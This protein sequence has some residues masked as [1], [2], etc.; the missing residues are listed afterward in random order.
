MLSGLA[1][2]VHQRRHKR[3]VLSRI[4]AALQRPQDASEIVLPKGGPVQ[5]ESGKDLR[6]EDSF[7]CGWPQLVDAIFQAMPEDLVVLDNQGEVFL[8]ARSL[9]ESFLRAKIVGSA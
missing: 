6:A 7:G 5:P 1:F 8:D 4:Q 9:I 2:S 3:R